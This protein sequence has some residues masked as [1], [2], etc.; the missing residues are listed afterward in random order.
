[1]DKTKEKLSKKS[2]STI[3]L[4]NKVQKSLNDGLDNPAESSISGTRQNNLTSSNSNNDDDDDDDYERDSKS[5][6]YELLDQRQDKHYHRESFNRP[7]VGEGDLNN[8][9]TSTNFSS[10]KFGIQNHF[11]QVNKEAKATKST[12]SNNNDDKNCG[13]HDNN[14]IEDNDSMT[15]QNND[16]GLSRV[17]VG[18]REFNV[19]CKDGTDYSSYKEDSGNDNN[20]DKSK[21]NNAMSSINDLNTTQNDGEG[22]GKEEEDDIN[23]KE[24]IDNSFDDTCVY[25]RSSKQN[26]KGNSDRLRRHKLKQKLKGTKDQQNFMDD[27]NSDLESKNNLKIRKVNFIGSNNW[28]SKPDDILDS[29]SKSQKRFSQ[30]KESSSI[31]RKSVLF[32]RAR[33]LQVGSKCN[34]PST[35]ARY[36]TFA[37][38]NEKF[39][40]PRGRL[41]ESQRPINPTRK[42]SKLSHHY[43]IRPAE[44]YTFIHEYASRE[45]ELKIIERKISETRYSINIMIHA[46]NQ[47]V[48]SFPL[49]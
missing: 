12:Y 34:M 24:C 15:R 20:S 42:Y 3:R 9:D 13:N 28:N 43:H 6:G 33:L 47:L 44:E 40:E 31:I 36:Q 25:N 23:T 18:R 30:C 8:N 41:N 26:D 37:Q 17:R 35:N 39:Q 46:T 7:L 45:K 4:E 5:N 48:I 29:K 21:D 10:D 27:N 22:E 16:Y 49:G 14:N 11:H 38:V 2:R 19:S 1:M 32:I